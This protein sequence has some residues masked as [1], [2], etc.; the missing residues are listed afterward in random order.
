MN[1][2][3]INQY[4]DGPSGQ[5][6]R[7]FDRAKILVRNGHSISIFRSSFSQYTL[8]NNDQQK[9]ES[10]TQTKE[11]GVKFI[12]IRSFP[13]KRNNWRRVV[14]MIGFSWTVYWIGRKFKES[15]DVIIGTSVHPVNGL[16]AQLLSKKKQSRFFF[17][18]TDLWPEILVDMGVISKK[19]LVTFILKRL[20]K[21]LYEKAEKIITV[22]PYAHE[23]IEGLGIQN[24]KIKWISN[25]VDLDY[26][27]EMEPYQGGDSNNLKIMYIGGHAPHLGLEVILE[28][29]KIIQEENLDQIKFIMIGD[30]MEKPGLMRK[31][32]ELN[33]KNIEFRDSVPKTDLYKSYEEADGLICHFKDVPMLKYGTS[34]FKIFDYLASGRP[35]IYGV[36]GKN[37]PVKES[38]SGF[39]IK[40][41]NPTEM[42]EA[43]KS[44][45]SMSPAERKLMGENG[46]PYVTKHYSMP[47]LAAKL[48]EVL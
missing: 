38:Q 43:I 47:V 21:Y 6:T 20:E 25:G 1:I 27:K 33:L 31:A 15:P 34:M 4:A 23:Y 5:A 22:L 40:P 19:S 12:N 32:Q 7:D 24:E 44:L 16:S 35:I 8:Q 3:I 18:V 36:N 9:K 45:H 13:Y 14:N 26:F 37:N 48:E 28:T 17:A 2:W 41:E 39:T 10:Y 46:P 30:G 29:A 11:S 42:S